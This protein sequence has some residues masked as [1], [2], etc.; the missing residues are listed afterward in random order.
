MIAEKIIDDIYRRQ[1]EMLQKFNRRA[2]LVVYIEDDLWCQM[3]SEIKGRV[4]SLV[5]DVIRNEGD[6]IA[7]ARIYKVIDAP[8]HGYKIYVK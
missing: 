4:P 1:S 6:H 2:E 7:G 3:M 8:H 5:Y